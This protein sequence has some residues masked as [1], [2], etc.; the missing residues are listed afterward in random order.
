MSSQYIKFGFHL[1]NIPSFNVLKIMAY[2]NIKSHGLGFRYAIN[3]T[4]LAKTLNISRSSFFM[5]FDTAMREGLIYKIVPTDE[6]MDRVKHVE[7]DLIWIGVQDL[8]AGVIDAIP[9]VDFDHEV[10]NYLKTSKPRKTKE[11]DGNHVS[12]KI[13]LSQNETFMTEIMSVQK[14]DGC[15]PNF[16]LHSD[17]NTEEIKQSEKEGSFAPTLLNTFAKKEEEREDDW[18]TGAEN[19][20]SKLRIKTYDISNIND[21]DIEECEDIGNKIDIEKDKGKAWEKEEEIPPTPLSQDIVTP[22]LRIQTFDNV[23]AIDLDNAEVKIISLD[24][25]D[26][27]NLGDNLDKNYQ[28]GR[29]DKNNKNIDDKNYFKTSEGEMQDEFWFYRLGFFGSKEAWKI[30]PKE[31]CTFGEEKFRSDA[32]NRVL[33]DAS[34]M[35]KFRI[36]KLVKDIEKGQIM[37]HDEKQANRNQRREFAMASIQPASAVAEPAPR[38]LLLKEKLAKERAKQKKTADAK[39]LVDQCSTLEEIKEQCSRYTTQILFA[40]LEKSAKRRLSKP[41]VKDLGRLN[42]FIKRCEDEEIDALEMM[43][44]IIGLIERRKKTLCLEECFAPWYWSE[45]FDLMVNVVNSAKVSELEVTIVR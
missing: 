33:D 29:P 12:P 36:E 17:T 20:I 11:A 45:A 32:L 15:S 35:E 34:L 27:N 7:D 19:E 39:G 38:T 42:Q 37:K 16:G 1:F 10:E 13:R 24:K 5:A 2:L 4:M 22:N 30:V 43:K 9:Y 44:T 23:D 3:K 31:L 21:I 26:K 41:L 25:N 14:L 40:Y 6:E 18:E 8:N 28:A